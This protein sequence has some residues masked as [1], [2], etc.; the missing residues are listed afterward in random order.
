MLMRPAKMHANE[1]DTDT[2]LVGRLLA[3]Q[4]PQVQVAYY[5]ETQTCGDYR[6]RSA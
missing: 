4:F 1:L 5:P 6:C 3:A 2:L